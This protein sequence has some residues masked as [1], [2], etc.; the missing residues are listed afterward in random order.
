[1]NSDELKQRADKITDSL[2]VRAVASPYT[3]AILAVTHVCAFAFGWWL[4]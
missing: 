2:L 4:K 3:W 1:M